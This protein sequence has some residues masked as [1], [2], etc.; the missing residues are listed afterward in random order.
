MEKVCEI[1][2]KKFLKL[3]IIIGLFV[4]SSCQS[5][6]PQVAYTVYPIEFILN[7]LAKDKI[8]YINISDGSLILRSELK[9]DFKDTLSK[10]NLL[11]YFGGL[12]PYFQSFGD[13]IEASK[14]PLLDITARTN[15]YQFNRFYKYSI[16]EDDFIVKESKYYEDPIFNSIDIYSNDPYLWMDP[17]AMTSMAKQI[18][19]WLNNMFPEQKPF[20]EE[21]YQKLE[22]DLAH[23]DYEFQALKDRHSSIKIVTMTPSFGPWQ[24]NYGI[25]IYPVILSKYGVVPTQQQLTLIKQRIAAD[26]V[27]YIADEP[28]LPEDIKVI[29]DELVAELELTPISLHSVTFR[30][31]QQ[32]ESNKDFIDIMYE[33]L[34]ALESIE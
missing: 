23:L 4:L 9:P 3:F 33:N 8:T 30:T 27:K 13:E 31:I 22:I 16:S 34:A 29:Y 32:I 24:Q 10:S 21:N 6:Y 18:K 14:V 26:E 28:N 25:E 19:T 20:F 15:I 1:M 11:I 7:R 2:K 17:I 12:E 5:K